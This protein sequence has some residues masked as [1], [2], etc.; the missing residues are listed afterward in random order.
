MWV[1]RSKSVLSF[2]ELV[3]RME[4]FCTVQIKAMVKVDESQVLLQGS[5]ACRSR[6]VADSFHMIFQRGNACRANA[7]AKKV[8]GGHTK[9][10]LVRVD[11]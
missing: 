7:V 2:E 6:K 11:D 1:S 8:E 5:L 4:N 10:A 3:Q 9:L